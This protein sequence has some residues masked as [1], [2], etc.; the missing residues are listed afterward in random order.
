MMRRRESA[1]LNMFQNSYMGEKKENDAS[2]GWARTTDG[3][4]DKY[5]VKFSVNINH[6]MKHWQKTKYIKMLLK[7][8]SFYNV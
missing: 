7:I 4:A 2:P 8:L 5:E 1:T 3:D 6:Y